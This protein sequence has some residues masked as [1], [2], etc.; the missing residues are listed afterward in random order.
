M[1]IRGLSV[2]DARA[3]PGLGIALP[4]TAG[5]PAP[6]F[7]ETNRLSREEETRR[8]LNALS[9]GQRIPLFQPARTKLLVTG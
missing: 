6:C 8:I 1:E 2:R 7:E 5:K 3:L 4:Y 9:S